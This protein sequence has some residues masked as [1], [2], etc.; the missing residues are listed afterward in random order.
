MILLQF[1]R[2]HIDFGD[3][4]V[5]GA[6]LHNRNFIEYVMSR[7]NSWTSRVL[8]EAV[9]VNVLL[10]TSFLFKILNGAMMVLLWFGF[11][12][13]FNPKNDLKINYLLTFMLMLYPINVMG[14]AGWAATTLNY[15]WVLALGL[16][17]MI[18]IKMIIKEQ[19]VKWWYYLLAIPCLLYAANSE[20]MALI[21]TGFLVVLAIYEFIDKKKIHAGIMLYLIVSVSMLVF[22]LQAPGNARRLLWEIGARFPD[23]DSLSLIDK[24]TLG[25]YRVGEIWFG[26]LNGMLVVLLGLIALAIFQKREEIVAKGL[27]IA[28]LVLAVMV[29]KLQL[30]YLDYGFL[31]YEALSGGDIIPFLNLYRLKYFACIAVTLF[32]LGAILYI[33]YRIFEERYEYGFVAIIFSAGVLSRFMMAF[34]PTIFTS[35]SRTAF[36]LEMSLIPIA[37]ILLGKL[38]ELRPLSRSIV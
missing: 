13:L 21:L 4:L 27:A 16:A 35:G 37:M 17:S 12:R 30:F 22:H 34:S 33:L 19:P 6:V 36:F 14:E 3:D 32:A 24:T 31:H 25:I 11:N 1:F 15:L 29:P 23:F 28:L 5:F 7:Y 26:A 9:L 20:Q 18:P 2:V 38:K 10:L 8:I